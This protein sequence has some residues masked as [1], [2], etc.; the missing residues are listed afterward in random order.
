MTYFDPLKF[1][2]LEENTVHGWNLA[3]LQ[4]Q[5]TGKKYPKI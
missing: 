2:L 1:S 3:K 5:G 4:K